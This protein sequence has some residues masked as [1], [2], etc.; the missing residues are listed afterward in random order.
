MG[1]SLFLGACIAAWRG[2]SWVAA[3]NMCLWLHHYHH[4][5]IVLPL[6]LNLTFWGTFS[7]IKHQYCVQKHILHLLYFCSL[8]W[9][10]NIDIEGH[11]LC[12]DCWHLHRNLYVLTL[13]CHLTWYDLMYVLPQEER[14]KRWSY[15]ICLVCDWTSH[16]QAVFKQRHCE[17]CRVP[18]MVRTD[19]Y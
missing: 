2:G 9:Q 8:W 3:N 18:L 10:K 14:L 12:S 4:F 11:P 6:F 15:N 5:C 1:L 17:E 13:C 19:D 7:A 16:S